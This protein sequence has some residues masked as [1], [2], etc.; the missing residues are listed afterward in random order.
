[1]KI[2]DFIFRFTFFWGSK[3]LTLWDGKNTCNFDFI[4]FMFL[5]SCS[6][7]NQFYRMKHIK[8]IKIL[9][10]G[11]GLITFKRFSSQHLKWYCMIPCEHQEHHSCYCIWLWL[12]EIRCM[13]VV[14]QFAILHTF[15]SK[16]VLCKLMC[17]HL[18]NRLCFF[19]LFFLW[20][21]HLMP[22]EVASTH[23]KYRHILFSVICY[24]NAWIGP[25]GVIYLLKLIIFCTLFVIENQIKPFWIEKRVV[26]EMKNHTTQ[27][28]DKNHKISWVDFWTHDLQFAWNVNRLLI[29]SKCLSIYVYN[30]INFVKSIVLT[31]MN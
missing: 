13:P 11:T 5:V 27:I 9:F 2:R 16:K 20:Y 3:K 19:S 21:W 15:T 29:K 30:G 4:H 22:N 24:Y 6:V 17:T 8:Y 12:F 26:W 28:L 31:F 23:P 10:E 14:L 25:E 7:F 1:M 18:L